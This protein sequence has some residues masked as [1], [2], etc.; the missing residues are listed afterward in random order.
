MTTP[1]FSC[2]TFDRSAGIPG[3]AYPWLLMLC[4]ALLLAP[5]AASAEESSRES[6]AYPVDGQPF[7]AAVT[8]IRPD[9]SLELSTAEGAKTVSAEALVRWGDY[10]DSYRDTQIHLNNGSVLIAD[11]LEMDETSL[12][13][14]G[15]I[16]GAAKL[17]FRQ[18]RGIIFDPPLENLARDRLVQRI[19]AAT[20]AK[21]LLLFENGDTV[22]GRIKGLA[23][24]IDSNGE[25]VTSVTMAA[26]SR[27]IQIPTD[28]ISAI[29]FTPQA[30]RGT[31]DDGS[32]LT[33]GFSD[34]SLLHVERMEDM[35]SL[36]DLHLSADVRLRVDPDVL[37][38]ELTFLLPQTPRVTYVSDLA[39]LAHRQVPLLQTEWPLGRDQNVMHG[40]LRS[41]QYVALK[42]LGM[43]A[44]ARV[45]AVLES[46]YRKFEAEAALDDQ[47]GPDGSVVFR[48]FLLDAS[49]QWQR[50]YESPVIRGSDPPLPIVVDVSGSQSI[51]LIADSADRGDVLDHADWLYARLVK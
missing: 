12:Q 13:V 18:V 46:G 50:A 44:T 7:A 32:H 11:I 41:D 20:G 9:W 35:R 42:G 34:G 37:L 22:G 25:A 6:V 5:L 8:K 1:A 21:D 45:A 36:M 51:A 47:S 16:C 43:H 24:T 33:L 28:K 23:N 40:R 27:E 26:A 15:D 29:V 48:V 31:G 30:T 4:S 38:E 3:L 19:F 10:R 14:Y 2:I 39:S 17:T 49:G